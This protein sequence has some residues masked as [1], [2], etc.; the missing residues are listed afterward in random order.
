MTDKLYLYRVA[1]P[2]GAYEYY[3]AYSQ[4]DARDLFVANDPNGAASRSVI[5]AECAVAQYEDAPV[6]SFEAQI[7]IDR[8]TSRLVIHRIKLS[9]VSSMPLA[10]FSYPP[11]G[12]TGSYTIRVRYPRNNTRGQVCVYGEPSYGL[13]MNSAADI[14]GVEYDDL[15]YIGDWCD[16]C[17]YRVFGRYILS[18]DC[19]SRQSKIDAIR[20]RLVQSAKRNMAVN[21]ERTTTIMEALK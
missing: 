17:Y 9:K 15:Y 10:V 5:N 6:V 11:S 2:L 12:R 13:A 7:S 21:I 4:E 8:A 19:I 3:K 20:D 1:L 16:V 18:A 14:Y